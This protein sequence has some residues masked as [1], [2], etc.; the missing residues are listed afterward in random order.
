MGDGETSKGMR[1]LQER[2]ENVHG[3][4]NNDYKHHKSIPSP[5]KY[6][7]IDYS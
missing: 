7:G 6:S 2:R 4:L 3:E 1:K 5:K